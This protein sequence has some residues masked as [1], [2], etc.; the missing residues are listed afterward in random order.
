MASDLAALLGKR[1][2]QRKDVKAVQNADGSWHPER[3][4]WQMADL[5]AHLDGRTTFGHYLLDQDGKTKL[6]AFD[7]DLNK[8]G[9]WIPLDGSDLDPQDCN[10]REVWLT[11]GHPGRTFLT[12]Q[13]RTTAEALA[14][15]VKRL[16]GLPVA[17]AYSGS[18]GLHVYAFTGEVE[19]ATARDLGVMVLDSFDG[20]FVPLRG[21]SFFEPAGEGTKN[22]SIE[23]YPKQ[24][25]LEGKDL[26]NLMRLPL[27]KHRRSGHPGFFCDLT[28]PYHQLK[29]VADP[30]AV[31]SEGQDW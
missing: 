1:F 21:G 15:R 12:M 17:V 19:A 10:P 16:F 29:P 7:I 28:T 3:A 11:K 20:G 22:L 30:I 13:L 5:E 24:S 23:I 8:T 9:W 25:S 27:G 2:I 6:F 31:L 18:K 4:R 26:G 14:G